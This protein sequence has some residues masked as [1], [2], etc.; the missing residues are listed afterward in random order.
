MTIVLFQVQWS[1][2]SYQA[3]RSDT[4]LGLITTR[5]SGLSAT[6]YKRQKKHHY[7]ST[8]IALLATSLDV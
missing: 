7:D 5:P 2:A 8:A 6:D 1:I 4:M 3:I